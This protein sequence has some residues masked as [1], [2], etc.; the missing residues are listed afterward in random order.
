MNR[1]TRH[2]YALMIAKNL[3]IVH[4]FS[5]KEERNSFLE[6]HPDAKRLTSVEAAAYS[7]HRTP[8]ELKQILS[9]FHL[10]I[11]QKMKE[12]RKKKI[13]AVKVEVEI[14]SC[15]AESDEISVL[16]SIDPKNILSAVSQ[17]RIKC[18]LVEIFKAEKRSPDFYG[19]YCFFRTD[20]EKKDY[21]VST[22]VPSDIFIK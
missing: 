9:D 21:Y 19:I 7:C 1:R 16:Y 20:D 3:P 4:E 5:N 2:L 15:L 18:S 14:Y 6:L 11:K 13:K 17:T 12:A 10:E 22:E 8:E